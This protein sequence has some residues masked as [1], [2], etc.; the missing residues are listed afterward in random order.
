MARTFADT[1]K[2]MNL[3]GLAVIID[4]L[5]REILLTF[6]VLQQTIQPN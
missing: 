2:A 3:I 6:D 5:Q 1:N 4:I